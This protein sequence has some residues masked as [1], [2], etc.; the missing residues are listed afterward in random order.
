[1]K[2]TQ[3][4]WNKKLISERE[5]AVIFTDSWGK[6]KNCTTHALKCMTPGGKTTIEHQCNADTHSCGSG[7]TL[8]GEGWA[9][10]QGR[11]ALQSAWVSALGAPRGATL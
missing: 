9:A 8:L 4:N 3:Q 11:Y 6:V 7:W 5:K 2:F 1:M 10:L